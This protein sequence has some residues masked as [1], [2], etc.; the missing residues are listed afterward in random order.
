MQFLLIILVAYL[1]HYLLKYILKSY[2]ATRAAVLIHDY[3]DVY[4]ICL[5]L[6][7][8]S[9]NLLCLR[10]K[11]RMP[12]E[13]L[14][15]EVIRLADVL[16]HVFDVQYAAYIVYIIQIDGYSAVAILH[17]AAYHVLE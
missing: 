13:A 1:A 9:V 15:A 4:L 17:N 16:Q 2:D 10:H 6:L 5:K 3:R 12:Y 8:Q 11:M 14:P 7:Q